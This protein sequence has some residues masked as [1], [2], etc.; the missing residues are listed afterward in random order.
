MF[1]KKSKLFTL[2][3]GLA[4]SWG[5]DAQET[6]GGAEII[7]VNF[8]HSCYFTALSDNGQWAV[9]SGNDDENNALSA[10][11]YLVNATT[12]ELTQLWESSPTN[13]TAADVTDDGKIVVGST[14][15]GP[16]YYNVDTRQW[17]TLPGSGTP[18]SVTPDGSRIVGWTGGRTLG[19]DN[20]SEQPVIWDRQAD[21]TYQQRNVYS[22]FKN[23]PRQDKNGRLTGIVRIENMSADGNI[24][25]GAINF[26]Y[27]QE[28]CYYVYNC[29]TGET[30]Y[31]D[32]YMQNV[33]SG[34]F[35][36]QSNISN[37]GAYIT[38]LANIV[39][40]DNEFTSAY[41]YN[42]AGDSFEMYTTYTDE[43][44][45]G[46]NAVSNTGV[47]FAASPAVN[48]LRYLYV[49]VGSLW[50]GLD[51]IISG[52]Y[53]I[54]IYDKL[55][56]ETTGTAVDVSDDERVL[57][58]MSMN[59]NSGYIVRL[60]ETFSEAASHIDPFGAYDIN[61]AEGSQ[62]TRFRTATI[63]FTKPVTLASSTSQAQFLDSEGNTV[64]RFTIT[65][66]T[67]GTSFNIGGMPYPMTAGEQYTLYFPAGTFMLTADNS[68]SNDDIR[69]N[70]VGRENTPAKATQITPYDG[71]N[72]SELSTNNPVRMTFDMN[73]QVAT[74]E[75]GNP[76]VGYLYEGD[77]ESPLCELTIAAQNN[78]IVMAPALRRYLR[79]DTDYRV[80]L[81]AG[82]VTDI[83]GDCGNEE[84]SL[85]YHGIYERQPDGDN[86]NL[87]F[88]EFADPANSI[89]NFLLYEG[90][91]N[92][93]SAAMQQW[94]FDTDNNPW[95]FT[96]RESDNSS[97]YCAASHSM[98]N[99]AGASDDW[100]SLPQ[101]II[102]NA[103][104]YLSFN[105]QSYQ[106]NKNDVL[107]VVILEDD[108]GY[109]NFTSELYD[110]F[111]ANGQVVFEQ[112]L[113]PG[114]SEEELSG[115][116]QHFEIPLSDYNGKSIYIAFV[117][118]NENQSAIF[119]DSIRVYYKG[120]FNLNNT[121]AKTVVAQDAATV[122][123]SISITGD[124]TY[125]DLTATLT[126]ES[127]FSSTYT[128]TD[129]GLSSK[130][131]PYSFEFPDQLPLTVGNENRY[132]ISINLDGNQL[133]QQG[134][135]K[136][137]AF[138]TTKRVVIEK[139]TGTECGFCP[140][141]IL[142]FENLERLFGDQFIPVEIHSNLMGSDPY[143]MD[144]Y[145]SYFGVSALPSG[146][147]NR[148]DTIY[149]ALGQIV[150]PVSFEQV[151]SYNSESGNE[152]YLDIVQREFEQNPNPDADITLTT[153]ACDVES[154]TLSI[155][156]NVNYAVNLS[157]LN[158]NI[159][160]VVLENGL[161]GRQH[162]YYV[163]YTDPMF[164]D[165][166]QGGI[167]GQSYVDY[168]YNHVARRVVN[169]SYAGI[170]GLIPLNVVAG[171][172]VEFSF[173]VPMYDNVYNWGNAE[174]VAMLV[175]NNTGLVI[176]STVIPFTVNAP[177]GI[178]SAESADGGISIKG[179]DGK[180][181]VSSASDVN[182]TVTGINGSLAGTASGK[183]EVSVNVNG[184][185]G[186]YVVKAT[187]DD[188]TIIRK[189][190]VR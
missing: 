44:D 18:T 102:E 138:E 65:A 132:T 66:N 101:L 62:F 87:F 59:K 181:T 190:V 6:I 40:G 37:N 36:D 108:N 16:A 103:D 25:A 140:S 159:V 93:P 26:I 55:G 3:L 54:N 122:S 85:T 134:N 124:D 165:W 28:A 133:S 91:H 152:T 185:N 31:I 172:P 69:I 27:P 96:I 116:W 180:V 83:M 174:L 9:A 188:S 1:N 7:P 51:E 4:F 19:S 162:N 153:A 47:V 113:N 41:R 143:A 164:S 10:Y 177:T 58:G 163:N 20:Y 175:D 70:Y 117:N 79:I 90:D 149:T 161:T 68:F 73:V 13:Y 182:V 53:G 100:M 126:T 112:Q 35:I 11:P 131:K 189:V 148:I 63:R 84:I 75:D 81:P 71:S 110:K 12:G 46:G 125:N 106:F 49:R 48:P 61:P 142:A 119:V 129:L 169:D 136:D 160:F 60:P 32:N 56:T 187:T 154:R 77:N 178:G 186:I 170:T 179:G 80:V 127:G 98:Y 24:L 34:S 95:N 107:K 2:L 29:T 42:I 15:S 157:S 156:G 145:V 168:T 50:Y 121:T 137:L 21:G 130:S 104:Y 89:A 57:L 147:V 22:E 176:N 120:D 109:T 52:R 86:V 14:P 144:N 155:A 114:K 158:Q 64:R 88:D 82:S 33:V 99:P 8:P 30:R 146:F 39:T 97:D 23:F 115:D 171:E 166:A 67:D 183:G 141:G 74:D 135:I 38:G 92:T 128:A 184:G 43:Q 76:A 118:Q 72:V 45:R 111:K 5:A 78:Q 123:A 150:D 94:G 151:Y 139:A 167:Y 17:V 105:A 173:N